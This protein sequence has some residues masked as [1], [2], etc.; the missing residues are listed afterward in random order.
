MGPRELRIHDASRLETRRAFCAAILLT[1]RL[2]RSCELRPR[3][4]VPY[5]RS[6]PPNAPIL[7]RWFAISAYSYASNPK[8]IPTQFAVHPDLTDE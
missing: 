8:R 7:C 6:A 1:D 3:A 2:A 5:W 4:A